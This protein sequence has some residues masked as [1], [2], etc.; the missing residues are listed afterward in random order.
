MDYKKKVNKFTGTNQVTAELLVN[1]ELVQTQSESSNQNNNVLPVSLQVIT[2]LVDKE[3]VGRTIE[4][5]T[6]IQSENETSLN[7]DTVEI[8]DLFNFLEVSEDLDLEDLNTQQRYEEI[9]AVDVHKKNQL[10]YE[11]EKLMLIKNG[12]TVLKMRK[13]TPYIWK[14][15]DS[16]D[17]SNTVSFM[18]N[19]DNIGLR[20]FK[21]SDFDEH[22]FPYAE[23]YI[24][25]YPSGA[26]RKN[27]KQMN[28]AIQESNAQGKRHV[29]LVSPKE[30][31][32][33][34][35][36]ILAA[37]ELN[38]GEEKLFATEAEGLVPAPGFS[39]YMI[40]D[41][42]KSIKG[43]FPYSF[44]DLN[45]ISDPWFR[46]SRL[47]EAFNNKRSEIVC[48]SRK[49]TL[50]ESMCSWRPRTTETGGLPNISYIRRK[51]EPLGTEFKVSACTETKCILYLEIQRG[52]DAMRAA[53]GSNEHGCTAACS[54]RLVKGSMNCG[55][56]KGQHSVRN[57]FLGDSWFASIK[58]AQ[59]VYQEGH[60][61]IG[62]IKTAH[63]GYPKAEIEQL[64]AKWPGGSS[65]VLETTGPDNVKLR[66]VG[67]KYN[68]RQALCFVLTENAGGT[69][70][71]SP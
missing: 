60:E 45:N 9:P 67:Y 30:W 18:N 17:S 1:V 19:H 50:D 44:F 7:N 53:E 10:L 3:I 11:T 28:K 47:V 32:T 46:I 25:L 42:F 29:R 16:N 14:V 36:L 59:I 41:R 49:K 37:A 52:R 27:L 4:E 34:H 13:G 12:H 71:G 40:L 21:F 55:Q 66:A 62:I 51:P 23:M 15:I 54:L 39:S 2:D 26:W 35:A 48:A 63:A 8:D 68:S 61:F 64:M 38:K 33:F 6:P 56:E 5:Q 69:Q 57:I 24:T 20:G 31:W 43:Y 70:N 65:I 22:Q 58:T